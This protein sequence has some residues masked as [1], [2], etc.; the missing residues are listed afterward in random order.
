MTVQ[1]S[2]SPEAEARMEKLPEGLNLRD[3]PAG[4]QRRNWRE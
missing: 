2:S 4:L 3:S 1:L